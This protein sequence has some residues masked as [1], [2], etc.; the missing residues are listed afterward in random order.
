MGLASTPDCSTPLYT[1]RRRE[2]YKAYY[3][4][5]NMP[6]LVFYN[7]EYLEGLKGHRMEYLQFWKRVAHPKGIELRVAEALKKLTP[8]VVAFAE[9]GGKNFIESD[10]FSVIQRYLGMKHHVKRAKYDFRGR[11]NL[12]KRVPFLNQQSN[13]ILSKEKLS[14][15]ET[16]YL[17][18]GMKRTV[19]KAG[20]EFDKKVT[21]LLVHLALFKDTR[22]KQIE[23]L[24]EIVKG[25][26]GPVILAGDLNTF[27][28]E[29]EI[30]KL[31][32]ESS[33]KHKFMV[34][35]GRIFTYPSFHPRRRLDYI[36]T[37][38]EIKIKKYDVLKLPFSDHL[39]VMVDFEV[40][41][42]KNVRAGT[43]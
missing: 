15:I 9:V 5:K 1:Y 42:R 22:K 23:E 25:V 36:L 35:G 14:G 2:T 10:Y 3:L 21:L 29:H 7:I 11:F 34:K 40:K 13:A 6:R 19:I 8:D 18:E 30:D 16:I 24:I 17:H 32:K 33:L 37:S 26:E 27:D 39:P 20:V 28:G 43:R 4:K 41:R 12:L 31:L 38:P